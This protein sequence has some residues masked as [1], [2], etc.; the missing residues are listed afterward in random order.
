[1]WGVLA[2]GQMLALPMVTWLIDVQSHALVQCAQ[3]KLLGIET[4]RKERL[5]S[6]KH[7]DE[8]QSALGLYNDSSI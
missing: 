5:K 4:S 1:M 7:S 3:V 6:N 8:R 2:L